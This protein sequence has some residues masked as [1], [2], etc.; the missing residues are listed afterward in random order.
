M[1]A[2]SS[3]AACGSAVLLAI[4][5]AKQDAMGR[6]SVCT[7]VVVASHANPPRCAVLVDVESGMAWVQPSCL[8]AFSTS[9]GQPSSDVSIR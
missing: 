4:K 9:R 6:T 2:R 7:A 8:A 3:S 1:A 5:R